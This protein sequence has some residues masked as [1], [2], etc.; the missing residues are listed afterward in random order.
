MNTFVT[1]GTGMTGAH[2]LLKLTEKGYNVKA[3]KREKSNVEITRK[4]FNYHS[5]KGE[6]LFSKINWITGDILDYDIINKAL[7]N[8]DHVYH[9]AAMVS[10]KPSE[11]HKM[12][13]NN[14]QGTAN[15]VNASL[16]NKIN[17]LCHVSSVAA[18]GETTIG[19]ELTEETEKTD[20]KNVSGYAISKHRSEREVWRGIAEGLNAVIV[21]P[22]VILGAG[23]WY[24]GSPRM[25]KTAW[26]GLDYYTK[27]ENGFIDVRDVVNTMML[28]TESNI[29]AERFILNGENLPFRTVFNIIADNLNIKR[30]SKYAN[31][32][33]LHTLKTFDILKYYIS[34][35]EPR[36]TKHTLHSAQQIHTCSN[37]K[38]KEVLNYKFIPIDKSIKDICKIFLLEFNS[39]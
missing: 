36:L 30:P 4:I 28:L 27:G 39:I 11:R 8:I 1:G 37:K 10:F 2:L 9:T 15:I 26:E 16:K 38:I 20:Y 21:N 7:K 33:M 35:K 31:S 19:D 23:N 5:G 29:N 17:K 13:Y 12:I 34:N 25:F 14:V 22:S 32:F 24:H 6:E 3:L 18:L